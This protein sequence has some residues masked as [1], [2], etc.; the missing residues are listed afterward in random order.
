LALAPSTV[1][2]HLQLL[3]LARLVNARK[4][5]RWVYYSLAG[6]EAADEVKE[7]LKWVREALRDSRR[8]SG[9]AARL[10]GILAKD[11]KKQCG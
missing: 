6:K 8:I 11:P 10:P 5:G 3:H 4:D 9:D 2:K 7:C 1:S